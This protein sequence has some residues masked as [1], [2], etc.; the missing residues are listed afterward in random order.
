MKRILV[1]TD[2]SDT[3]A[4][5][6][7]YA[8]Q[9][10]TELDGEV[11]LLHAWQVPYTG[12]GASTLINVDALAQSSTNE[13]LTQQQKEMQE[14]FPNLQCHLM[15][16]SALAGN[17]IKDVCKEGNFDLIVMGTTGASGISEKL[18][19]STTASVIGK[20]G[21]PMVTVSNKSEAKLPGRI[22]VATDLSKSGSDGLFEPLKVLGKALNASIDFLNV[23]KEDEVDLKQQK[24]MAADFDDAFD[25]SYH[26]FH[27]TKNENIEE[28]ILDFI[29]GKSVQLLTVVANKHGFWESLFQKST[30][31]S[32]VKHANLPILVLPG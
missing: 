30:S 14:K 8:A 4:K 32:L 29:D 9:L 20:I 10:A 6:R 1:P 31:K 3:A 28:G 13:M 17:A 26:P 27:Y 11:T 15:N 22:L 12:A 16:L 25:M 2:F 7:D 19:G 24:L 18:I 21:I 5:A 23:Y